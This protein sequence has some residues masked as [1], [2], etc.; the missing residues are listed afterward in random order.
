MPVQR[1]GSVEAMNAAPLHSHG[2]D[3][4]AERFFRHCARYWR[5][6][7]RTYPR[8]VFRFRTL[9]EAQ[10]ARLSHALGDETR[11]SCAG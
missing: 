5:L 11:R 2:A 9:A 1:F 8:G 10:R 3:D 6:M 4:G 7:P